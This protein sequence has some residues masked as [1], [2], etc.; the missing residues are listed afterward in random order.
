MVK[1]RYYT[2]IYP[3]IKGECGKFITNSK[4]LEKEKNEV[5]KEDRGV[6]SFNKRKKPA[7]ENF[8]GRR[9]KISDFRCGGSGA[10]ANRKRL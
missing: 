2:N 4:R 6:Y 1:H 5:A 7:A 9:G 3:E 8:C 10:A